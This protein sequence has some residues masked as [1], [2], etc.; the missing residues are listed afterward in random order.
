MSE[1]Q[2]E[3]N[4]GFLVALCSTNGPIRSLA[5]QDF[6]EQKLRTVSQAFLETKGLT[7]ANSSFAL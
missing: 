1:C 6:K 5:D 3:V 7:A 2:S 4:F